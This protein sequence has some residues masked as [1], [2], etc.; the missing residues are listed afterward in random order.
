MIKDSTK[1][2]R[3]T[4]QQQ[5]GEI[6]GELGTAEIFL[7][8]IRDSSIKGVSEKTE[9]G[10]SITKANNR[11]SIVLN[12]RNESDI[13]D[14]RANLLP[15]IREATDTPPIALCVRTTNALEADEKTAL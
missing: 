6:N 7:N 9:I 10:T 12:G 8:G 11:R 1:I 15:Q 14:Q 4:G 3:H 13:A 2:Y 5:E